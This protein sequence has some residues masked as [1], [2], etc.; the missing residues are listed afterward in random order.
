MSAK[1]KGDLTTLSGFGNHRVNSRSQSCPISG[2]AAHPVPAVVWGRKKKARRDHRTFHR[3]TGRWRAS[4]CSKFSWST[5]VQLLWVSGTSEQHRIISASGESQVEETVD[6][7]PGFS[8][9]ST[10]LLSEIKKVRH[11][12]TLYVDFVRVF[13]YRTS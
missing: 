12:I 11:R 8:D 7:W 1:R 3:S 5:T 4:M 9:K 13:V 6:P 10:V 2:F